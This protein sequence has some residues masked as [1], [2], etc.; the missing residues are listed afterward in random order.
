M[1]A[2]SKLPE[3]SVSL[4]DKKAI[5]WIYEVWPDKALRSV[6]VSMSHN[7]MIWFPLPVAS[8]L[9]SGEKAIDLTRTGVAMIMSV[10]FSELPARVFN[11]S[12]DKTLDLGTFL[13]PRSAPAIQ[14]ILRWARRRLRGSIIFSVLRF[15]TLKSNKNEITLNGTKEQFVFVRVISWI[16]FANR[17]FKL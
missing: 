5:P 3:I 16:V 2:P 8:V 15:A 12:P 11:F 17:L 6:P 7:L 13:Q 10:I 4:S 1:M 9:P 14:L